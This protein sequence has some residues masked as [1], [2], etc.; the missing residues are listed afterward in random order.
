MPAT[1]LLADPLTTTSAGA[2]D[3][4]VRPAGVAAL[5][6]RPLASRPTAATAVLALA[7][8]FTLDLSRLGGGA[9]LVV[10]TDPLSGDPLG[11]LVAG[12]ALP[13][14]VDDL[15]ELAHGSD[16]VACDPTRCRGSAL[17]ATATRWG[18]SR[19]GVVPC[20]FGHDLVAIG[21]LPLPPSSCG[22]Q[23]LAAA[24]RLSE[25]F[26]AGVVGARLFA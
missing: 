24:R 6:D 3:T 25:R 17:R 23:V 20:T 12:P 1:R 16:P 9:A 14:V 10:L 5:L 11:H 15:T 19:V 22:S 26:G 18:A 13:D 4:A 21:L 8:R 7:R 2:A